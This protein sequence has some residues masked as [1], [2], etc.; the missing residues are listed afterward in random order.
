MSILDFLPEEDARA[1]QRATSPVRVP[2]VTGGAIAPVVNPLTIG[3][4]QRG[5]DLI[6]NSTQPAAPGT[7]PIS[8]PSI[9]GP[10]PTAPPSGG[11]GG[12]GGGGG[13]GAPPGS[14]AP[15]PGGGTTPAPTPTPSVGDLESLTAEQLEAAIG[16]IEADYGLTEVQLQAD[17]T[18]LGAR[19]RL[20]KTQLQSQRQ[21]A[22]EESQAG[23]EGRG[24]LRSGQRLA[25]DADVI[26]Q[27][28]QSQAALSQQQSSQQA[29]LAAQLAA[30]PGE[31]ESA[32]AQ[33]AAQ[34][35]LSRLELEQQLALL[36][37]N[38]S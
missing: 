9:T 12:F 19:Y 3:D 29:A 32:I 22:L 17:Q 15:P 20:L 18:E 23:F 25:A 5:I 10:A 2:S 21:V 28:G 4:I 7:S 11:G 38:V 30:L 36:N 37:N 14:P 34:L 6:A 16:A 1:R 26:S 35:G 8:L 33:A 24:I 27:F 13:G 31:R